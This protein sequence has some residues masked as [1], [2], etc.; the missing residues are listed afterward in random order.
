MDSGGSPR[1]ADSARSRR[2]PGSPRSARSPRSPRDKGASPSHWEKGSSP[3]WVK[4]PLTEETPTTTSSV[5]KK[6]EEE[7]PVESVAEEKPQTSAIQSS[8]H[9][10]RPTKDDYNPFNYES[11]KDAKADEENPHVTVEEYSMSPLN[12]ELKQVKTLDLRSKINENERNIEEQD[13]QPWWR[14]CCPKRRY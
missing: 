8:P 2:N 6:R 10:G 12:R 11:P 3:H 9:V 7:F 5:E 4:K 13:Q 1:S 14:I